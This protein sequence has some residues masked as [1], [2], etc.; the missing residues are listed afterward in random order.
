MD[1]S[2]S[3]IG[4]DNKFSIL[5]NTEEEDDYSADTEVSAD[6]V[7]QE[8]KTKIRDTVE[9]L[10]VKDVDDIINQC[11]ELHPEACESEGKHGM[12]IVSLGVHEHV[13]RL[14]KEIEEK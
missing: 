6:E 12:K 11:N 7:F 4:E 9:Y 14:E 1:D 8:R 13:S 2:Q 10:S 3:C 5:E